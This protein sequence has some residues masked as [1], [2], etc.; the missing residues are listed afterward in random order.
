MIIELEDKLT[1]SIH[2][3]NLQDQINNVR[4]TDF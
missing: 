3:S 4:Q 2:L 1:A